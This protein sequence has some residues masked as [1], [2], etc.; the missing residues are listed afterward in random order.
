MSIVATFMLMKKKVEAW[1][2]WLAIDILS[3]YMYYIKEVK[4]YALLYLIFCFI[5]AMGAFEWTRKYRL[6][7]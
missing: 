7:Q 2:M 6:G 1:W 4:L 5:A 3:T